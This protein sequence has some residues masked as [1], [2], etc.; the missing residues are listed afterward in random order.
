MVVSLL[1]RRELVKPRTILVW[2]SSSSGV[3][4]MA[5]SVVKKICDRGCV[6][7]SKAEETLGEECGIHMR[8]EHASKLGV[9]HRLCSFSTRK[10]SYLLS[11]QHAQ[12]A[13]LCFYRKMYLILFLSS[14]HC[15]MTSTQLGSSRSWKASRSDVRNCNQFM[16]YLK[17]GEFSVSISCWI[18]KRNNS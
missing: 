3:K 7:I 6:N 5:N 12:Y 18:E 15:V 13:F 2:K 8:A 11:K 17:S 10:I 14:C 16:A 9:E 4:R 1:K